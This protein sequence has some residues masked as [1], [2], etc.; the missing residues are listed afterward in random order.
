MFRSAHF[1]SFRG[2]VGLLI[3]GLAA[4]VCAGGPLDEYAL[5]GVKGDT[6][7]LV[8][9]DFAQAQYTNVGT[10]RG[11]GGQV[12]TG[13]EGSAFVPLNLNLFGFWT[14]PSDSLTK[15]LYINCLDAQAAI[16]GQDLGTGAV[17]GAT[18]AY[19]NEGQG[20]PSN[21]AYGPNDPTPASVAREKRLFAIQRVEAQEDDDVD[22]VIENGRVVGIE[23]FAA[24]VSVLGASITYNGQYNMPVTTQF[25]AAGQTYTP[26]GNPV[27][28]VTGNVNDENNPRH[29]VLPGMVSSGG[30]ITVYGK[31]WRKKKA[32]YDGTKTWHWTG[33]L[34]ADSVTGTPLIKVLRNGDPVPAVAA[35]ANRATIE[36]Y[37]IDFVDLPSGTM[38]LD[39]NQAIYLFELNTTNLTAPDA[40]FQDLVVL[41][42][43]AKDPA[44]LPDPDDDDADDGP[45]ARLVKV[46][47]KTGGYV[48][49][50]TLDNVY[51][52]LA[53]D[54]SG[55]F[56]V[57]VGQQLWSLDPATQTE[58]QLGTMLYDQVKGLE[59][60]GAA[61]Y[62]FAVV[63]DRLVPIDVNS[64]ATIGSVLDIQAANLTSIVFTRL[65]DLPVLDATD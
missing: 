23:P 49:L 30:S 63:S 53:S 16:V 12:F 26:F 1:P 14:D 24:R 7:D 21:E 35:F 4:Q 46:D 64:G 17:T 8:R 37:V 32:W 28:P 44:D 47:P 38:N 13:I 33:F 10:I 20:G 52:G 40:N 3:V 19:W 62:G 56:H 50:M 48:Q 31:S 22:F 6:A 36:D 25:T 65:V 43:L 58:T 29:F 27:N 11:A 57:T 60:A 39:E 41:V 59:F 45:S 5:L 51:D 55:R 9:F 54:G 15:V 61:L 18:V 2:L 42:T 34:T